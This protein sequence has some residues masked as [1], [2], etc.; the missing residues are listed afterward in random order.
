MPNGLLICLS[1]TLLPEALCHLLTSAS[2]V[3]LRTTV[4][5]W[6]ALNQ[7]KRIV[8]RTVSRFPISSWETLSRTPSAN[9]HRWYWISFW[10]IPQILLLIL[11]LLFTKVWRKNFRNSVMPLT[12][13]LLLSRSANSRSLWKPWIPESRAWRTHSCARRSLSAGTYHPSNRSWY[14][15]WIHCHRNHLRNRYQH[16]GFSFGKTLMFM[17]W[18]YPNQQWKRKEEKI[19]PGFQGRMLYQTFTG[20]MCECCCY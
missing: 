20:S 15:Q 14:Q 4:S 7:V 10:K 2:S 18:S 8:C 16:G 12:A 3:P 11:S 6:P 13:L 1:M 19:C 5:N 17:G 9:L